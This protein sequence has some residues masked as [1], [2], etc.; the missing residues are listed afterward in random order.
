MS[1]SKS[2]P[3]LI[4]GGGA[5]GLS[6]VVHLLRAGYKDITVLD[7]DEEIP[8]RWSA[9]ND[10]NK[11]VRAEYEDP[12]YQ[13][14]TVVSPPITPTSKFTG[15]G[16]THWPIRKQL[17]P[18]RLPCSLRIFIKWAFCIVFLAKHPKKRLIRSIDSALQ[19]SETLA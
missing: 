3:I 17:K 13:D 1:V 6:T 4:V 10:L 11:I 15:Q 12:L 18:G 19:L 2:E 14:L 5:F 16:L 8:S 9:A 7:K